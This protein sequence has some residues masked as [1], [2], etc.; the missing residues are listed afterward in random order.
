[1]L[2]KHLV[3]PIDAEPLESI[4]DCIDCFLGGAGAIGIFDAQQH[5]AAVAARV[6]PVEECRPR[7]ANMQESGRRG[8]EARH[9]GLGHARPS[10]T[11]VTGR[12]ALARA[13]E[14]GT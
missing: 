3:V 2:V 7:P 12:E 1:V 13:R 8:R 10:T 6:E 5:L 4:K 11:R 14:F 9:E